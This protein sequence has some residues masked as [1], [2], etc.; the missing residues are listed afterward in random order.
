[1]NTIPPDEHLRQA[2]RHA[3]DADVTAPQ[4]I[5][6]HILAAA[7]RSAGQRPPSAAPPPRPW[8]RWLAAWWQRP[9]A[10][11]AFAS[12]L[13]AGFVGFLWREGV[14]GPASDES[15][16]RLASAE[17]TRLASRPAPS[18]SSHPTASQPQAAAAVAKPGRQATE[19]PAAAGATAEL[20]EKAATPQRRE[21]APRRAKY[22]S[23]ETSA[24]QRQ[25]QPAA[26]APVE[27]D[28]KAQA[29]SAVRTEA[30]APPALAR[31][32]VPAAAAPAVT[33]PAAAPPTAPPAAPMPELRAAPREITAP[34]NAT[35]ADAGPG[36]PWQG[37][38]AIGDEWRWPAGG[39]L[40]APDGVW[41]L[42]LARATQGRWQLSAE[43]VP[44]AGAA[45]LDWQRNGARVGSLWF[46]PASV[47]WCGTSPPCHRAPLSVERRREL[48]QQLAR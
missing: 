34:L 2:L 9:A 28:P 10:T 25:P 26:I 46:E 11:A 24:V 29:G 37:G 18:H 42:S 38:P 41:W 21:L 33:A 31:M 6:A 43:V 27:P 20:A 40:R 1:M 30:Q 44:A 7:H 3:P 8:R 32:P 35:A 45:Q 23:E 4:A 14:P 48:L 22:L 16:A 17:A 13:M 39:A 12:V 47:L 36:L 5:S 15:P 19:M